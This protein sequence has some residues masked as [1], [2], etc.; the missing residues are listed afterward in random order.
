[1]NILTNIWSGQ[2]CNCWPYGDS[3]SGVSG[4]EDIL[5]D[6]AL[7]GTNGWGTLWYDLGLNILSDFIVERFRMILSF[8]LATSGTYFFNRRITR[9]TVRVQRG[10]TD[11]P[12]MEVLFLH[13]MLFLITGSFLVLILFPNMGLI[14]HEAIPWLLFIL[15]PMLFSFFRQRIQ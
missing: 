14:V 10:S 6:F 12:E 7:N 9:N 13:F 2:H 1:M 3:N 15:L 5:L 11:V 4:V 8:L